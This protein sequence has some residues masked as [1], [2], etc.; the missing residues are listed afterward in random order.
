LVDRSAFGKKPGF[1]QANQ[2]LL[3]T[4]ENTGRFA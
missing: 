3:K 4:L 2:A 1:W